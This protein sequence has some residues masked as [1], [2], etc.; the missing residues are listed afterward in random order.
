MTKIPEPAVQPSGYLISCLPEGHDERFLF[1]VQ[2]K[3]RGDGK[4][5]VY[6]RSRLL[7][8]D[9]TWTFGFQWS[10]GNAEPATDEGLAS[11]DKEQEAW[12]ADHRFDH[13]TALR[14]AKEAASKLTYRGYGVAEALAD[15]P[16]LT[17]PAP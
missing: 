12:L 16:S 17:T 4:W 11:F 13:D 9:G 3:Y 5:A 2:C 15:S 7:A 8:T 6:N 10:G 14:L 1:T